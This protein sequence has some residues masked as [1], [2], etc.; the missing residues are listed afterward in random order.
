MCVEFLINN[1]RPQF[2]SEFYHELMFLPGHGLN[3]SLFEILSTLGTKHKQ[4]R[5]SQLQSSESVRGQGRGSEEDRE[6]SMTVGVLIL[7]RCTMEG[8]DEKVVKSHLTCRQV[9]WLV[10][11]ARP[12]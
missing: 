7:E 8:G 12:R 5:M 6:C 1:H 9:S 11:Y 4:L 10:F 3:I 2:F